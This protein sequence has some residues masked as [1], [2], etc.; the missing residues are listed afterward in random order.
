MGKKRKKK[1]KRIIKSN[2]RAPQL[3]CKKI[4]CINRFREIYLGGTS[5]SIFNKL[6]RFLGAY[7]G[8]KV[9][10]S[11]VYLA[12]SGARPPE[13]RV[14][15]LELKI[16]WWMICDYWELNDLMSVELYTIIVL[17]IKLGSFSAWMVYSC[18]SDNH[19]VPSRLHLDA[20]DFFWKSCNWLYWSCNY[21]CSLASCWHDDAMNASIL[22]LCY[23]VNIFCYLS[24]IHYFSNIIKGLSSISTNNNNKK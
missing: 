7:F 24:K 6:F 1:K 21:S 22:T 14:S 8:P 2:T 5:F 20:L 3:N 4:C 10:L 11:W 23:R 16:S 9:Q 17:V 18:F 13:F 19:L 12:W 15:I